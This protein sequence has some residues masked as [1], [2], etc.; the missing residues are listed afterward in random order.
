MLKLFIADDDKII[1][2]GLRTMLEKFPERYLVIGEAANGR[3]AISAITE[4]KPDIVITDIKM[5]VMDGV[6]LIEKL[7]ELESKPKI[8]VLS[9]YDDYKYVRST[10]KYGAEDYILKPV[11]NKT[12]FELLDKINDNIAGERERK[13][14]V[15]LFT[16][17]VME[18][19]QVLKERLVLDIVRHS[20][21]AKRDYEQRLQELGIFGAVRYMLALILIDDL[22][23]QKE[24]E[25]RGLH[26]ATTDRLRCA[27]HTEAVCFEGRVEVLTADQNDCILILFLSREAAPE[28]M[29]KYISCFLQQLNQ[30]IIKDENFTVTAGVGE[31]FDDL[32]RAAIYYFRTFFAL[33]RRFY[34]GKNRI[35]TSIPETYCYEHLDQSKLNEE[36]S[37]LLNFIE[38]GDNRGVRRSVTA[39][40]EKVKSLNVSPDDFRE[41]L[42]YMVQR[43]YALSHE[44]REASENLSFQ[45]GGLFFFIKEL[46]TLQELEEYLPNEFS[47][48]VERMN[49]SRREKSKKVIEMAK[50]YIFNHYKENITLN[51]VSAVVFLNPTYFSELFRKETGKNFIDFLIETRIKAAK[52]LLVKPENKVY[53]VGQM[54]GYEE[55][56]S[57]NRAFKR[58]V[59]ISPAEYRNIIK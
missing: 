28:K 24:E 2:Q 21:E 34:E 13:K 40:M 10:M 4:L 35:I 52:K 20:Q 18:G 14:H 55:A 45:D 8:I 32:E 16:K 7:N 43:I 1:R 26:A 59:G 31:S 6:E 3:K 39:I 17:H 44:F 15:L 58:T 9:G 11:E 46:D 27:I 36:L 56:S 22:Y 12:F 49:M 23:K 48:T 33:N 19:T 25:V 54:V 38:I 29:E 47:H 41:I 53:E 50:E 42:S 30:K 51:S 5:P 57:F 37:L